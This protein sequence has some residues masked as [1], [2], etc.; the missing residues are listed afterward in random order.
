MDIYLTMMSTDPI[1]KRFIY[2]EW[3][4]FFYVGCVDTYS[5]Y[6]T[7][8][9]S[10]CLRDGWKSYMAQYCKKTCNLCGGGENVS[11]ALSTLL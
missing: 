7:K 4:F 9:A 3:A 11:V 10:N 1:D 8:Y 2:H 6:C 5:R